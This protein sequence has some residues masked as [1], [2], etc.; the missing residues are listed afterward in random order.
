MPGKE[1]NWLSGSKI[2]PKEL[3]FHCL[4]EKKGVTW[5]RGL[6]LKEEIP[7]ESIIQGF[8]VGVNFWEQQR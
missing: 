1:I 6:S 3:H 7:L 2:L 5:R 4:V 8:C